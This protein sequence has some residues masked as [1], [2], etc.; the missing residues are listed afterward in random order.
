MLRK[1]I[2]IFLEF[3][4]K[5]GLHK[6]KPFKVN[7]CS[8]NQKIPG[9]LSVDYSLSAELIINLNKGKLPFKSHSLGVVTCISAINYFTRERGQEIINEVYRVLD[10]GGIARFA[11]QDLR[12]IAKKYVENDIDFFFQKLPDGS[13][14]FEGKTMGDKFNSWFYGYES[15][16]GSCKYFYDFETLSDMFIIAGFSVVK[17]KECMESELNYIELID[18]RKSQMFFLEAIK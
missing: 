2:F 16:T 17:E 1:I 14:R 9:Y 4:S 10:N 11:S 5:L 3:Y 18:N 13:E 15:G 12:K 7:L 6:K 8:G